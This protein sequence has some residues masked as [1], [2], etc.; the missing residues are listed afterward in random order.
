M[1]EFANGKLR[2][3][4]LPPEWPGT[5]KM[6]MHE[7]NNDQA[8]E[9][10]MHYL[11]FSSD[12]VQREGFF[13]QIP[14]L[15]M[16][17]RKRLRFKT[18]NEEISIY[19]RSETK[20]DRRI[21]RNIAI[22]YM[23]RK[24]KIL[25]ARGNF[26]DAGIQKQFRPQMTEFMQ[27]EEFRRGMA[28]PEYQTSDSASVDAAVAVDRI[29]VTDDSG[30]GDVEQIEE[31]E[32]NGG[33]ASIGGESVGMAN[34]A[35]S[36]AGSGG[37]GGANEGSE[38]RKPSRRGIE[39]IDILPFTVIMSEQRESEIVEIISE[40]YSFQSQVLN[41]QW[42][43][44]ASPAGT[45]FH[46]EGKDCYGQPVLITKNDRELRNISHIPSPV[47]GTIPHHQIE[48]RLKDHSYVILD[49]HAQMAEAVKLAELQHAHSPFGTK[50]SECYRNGGDICFDKTELCLQVH[51]SF[52]ST[53]EKLL[54]K[55]KPDIFHIHA[56][57]MNRKCAY[58]KDPN[59]ID[60]SGERRQ[61]KL[62]DFI[63]PG[64]LDAAD[65]ERVINQAFP[66]STPETRQTVFAGFYLAISLFSKLESETHRQVEGYCGIKGQLPLDHHFRSLILTDVEMAVSNGRERAVGQN[67]HNDLLAGFEGNDVHAVGELFFVTGPGPSDLGECNRN[68]LLN[69]NLKRCTR[70]SSELSGVQPGTKRARCDTERKEASESLG[71]QERIGSIGVVLNSHFAVRW[72][73]LFVNKNWTPFCEWFK[74]RNI[75]QK[76][77]EALPEKPMSVTDLEHE[78]ILREMVW[79]LVVQKEILKAKLPRFEVVLLEVERNETILFDTDLIHFGAP[80]P[81]KGKIGG[82]HIRLHQYYLDQAKFP[83]AY[84]RTIDLERLGLGMRPILRLF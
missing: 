50:L 13:T 18:P 6:Q 57:R 63:D 35:E 20:Y 1:R 77:K 81:H 15:S 47:S 79:D 24:Y 45:N 64:K 40:P 51:A 71:S 56:E 55:K 39:D 8:A 5:A 83:D 43:R 22:G 59:D 41:T 2:F 3:E 9:F 48:E 74:S 4:T 53:G 33:G 58:F 14:T 10:E 29:D 11:N 66:N 61:Y 65:L 25:M 38:D 17:E 54:T 70:R 7:L 26:N 30:S 28:M 46:P 34:I 78:E 36:S 49:R 37:C 73:T 21:V 16:D 31:K 72:M 23:E 60:V 69:R 27:T 62:A 42:V 32:S 44:A 67:Y 68:A 76:C 84:S 12:R 75:L 52:Q 80:Y 82:I 19:F